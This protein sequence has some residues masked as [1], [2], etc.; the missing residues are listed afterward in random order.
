MRSVFARLISVGINSAL[1]LIWAR[2]LSLNEFG[3]LSIAIA[4]ALF[5]YTI[6]DF[7]DNQKGGVNLAKLLKKKEV[8]AR[9]YITKS[10]WHKSCLLLGSAGCVALYSMVFDNSQE[11]REQ[12]L[13]VAVQTIS[14]L[15]LSIANPWMAIGLQDQKFFMSSSIFPRAA[16]IFAFL[17]LLI[18]NK[19]PTA[20]DATVANCLAVVLTSMIINKMFL[21]KNGYFLLKTSCALKKPKL[22][23]VR[24]NLLNSATSMTSLLYSPGLVLLGGYLGAP[25][26]AGLFNIADRICRSFIDI[27]VLVYQISA[28]KI[29]TIY[30]IEDQAS[31]RAKQILIRGFLASA[32]FFVMFCMFGEQALNVIFE[33]SKANSI[34][35]V[36][37]VML[38]SVPIVS[39]SGW[40][41]VFKI[42]RLGQ[43]HDALF[44]YAVCGIIGLLSYI[45]LHKF[46][47]YSLEVAGCLSEFMVMLFLYRKVK[48]EMRYM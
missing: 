13:I 21:I 36:T 28:A 38:A 30:K 4:A 22:N 5:I 39:I 40:L 45:A 18:F 27:I 33:T 46:T 34:F 11:G 16:S 12:G 15:S 44:S 14:M 35:K 3:K 24:E 2:Y 7:G 23:R 29:S 42:V 48:R 8:A 1:F 41:L 6:W 17:A 37:L 32:T 43:Y 9:I 31:R 25:T 26:D 10:V 19:N 47:N 20:L